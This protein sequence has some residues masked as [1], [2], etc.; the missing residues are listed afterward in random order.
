[1]PVLA[2]N[3]ASMSS[4]AFFI[5]AAAKVVSVLF[6][7]LAGEKADPV[8]I[9]KA[10]NNPAIRCIRA[11]HACLRRATDCARK[12]GV[13]SGRKGDGGSAVPWNPKGLRPRGMSRDG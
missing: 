2:A 7:A 4:S 13:G 12:S 10:A 1:M 8:R 11:L 5:E 9:R 3:A 6:L